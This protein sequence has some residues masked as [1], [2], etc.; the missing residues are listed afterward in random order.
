VLHGDAPRRYL[1]LVALSSTQV[2]QNKRD[3]AMHEAEIH[4]AMLSIAICWLRSGHG[5]RFFVH[6]TARIRDIS[7]RIEVSLPKTDRF[8]AD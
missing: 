7:E 3:A 4:S 8:A 1:V 6:W 2:I 5:F